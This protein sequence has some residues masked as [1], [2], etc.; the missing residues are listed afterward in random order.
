MNYIQVG[1]NNKWLDISY[2]DINPAMDRLVLTGV[3][4][5]GVKAILKAGGS[6]IQYYQGELNSAIEGSIQKYIP[7]SGYVP[8]NFINDTMYKIP[9][10]Y[11]RL[12]M[13]GRLEL[14]NKRD[15]FKIGLNAFKAKDDINSIVYGITPKDNL[16]V[17]AD[18]TIKIFKR[19]L[20]FSFGAAVSAIT[21]DISYGVGNKQ[22]IDTVFH[23]HLP[24]DPADY[25]QYLI[26]NSSTVPIIPKDFNYAAYYGNVSLTNKVQSFSFEYRRNGPQY[27]SLGNPFLRTNYEG[28]TIGERIW[29]WKKRFSLYGNYQDFT[30]DLNQTLISSMHT[31][32]I[33]GSFYF[34]YKPG[35][36]GLMLNYIS[37]N[38]NTKNAIVSAAKIDDRMEILMA[39]LNYSKQYLGMFHNIRIV[40][41]QT[42]RSD[43]VR[44]E[45]QTVFYNLI[46]GISESF[47]SNLVISFD[48]GRTLIYNNKQEYISDLNI[49]SGNIS[50]QSKKALVLGLNISNNMNKATFYSNQS[51]RLSV[52]GKFGFRIYK[53]MRIDSEYGYQ[54]YT[55]ESNAQNNYKEQY[56]YVRYTYDF[57]FK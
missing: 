50:W 40:W 41:N 35:W 56:I 3:R 57:N 37:Q 46:G 42:R 51:Q 14:G 5:R 34:G 12:M 28:Y 25:Q 9:G 2:G 55:D 43:F 23:T 47:K 32:I 27:T 54:P 7:G 39:N 1:F 33:N 53:G 18:L 52:I 11:K 30:N 48:A 26:M 10:T 15:F 19:R 4:I 20:A 29:F 38:R 44:P 6:S 17:G 22:Q 24:Y 21:N 31:Q 16:A 8:S 13:A 45:T 36:P 49:Y